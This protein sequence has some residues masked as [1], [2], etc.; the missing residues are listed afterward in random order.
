MYIEVDSYCKSIKGVTVLENI[1]C[2]FERGRVYG[3]RGKNGS[4]KTMLLRALSGL[5]FPTSGC[6][7]IGGK[8]LGKD[9]PFPESIG[10]LIENPSFL[11]KYTGAKN[12]EL[13]AG[14]RGVI[15]REEIARAMRSVGLDPDDKRHYRK[16][17]LGMKQRLGIA[18]AIMEKPDILLL[19]EPINALDP[20]G[21]AQVEQVL[22][23]ARERGAVAIVACH[24]MEELRLLA[25][26]ILT[27][28]EGRITD[29]E[30]VS[31]EQA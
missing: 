13:I 3:L 6:V 24:D 23:R 11:A 28:A 16:Y 17:S 25:D 19:D 4:G 7:R 1:S 27:L 26:E 9:M 22:A 20:T 10:L 30:V 21:V 15:G 12:L 14:L 18:C 31:H 8:R 29:S 2:G 5:I